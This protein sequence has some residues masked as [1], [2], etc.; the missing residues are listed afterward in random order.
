MTR[1]HDCGL[2]TRESV[3]IPLKGV[4]VTGAIIGRSARVKVK[5]H[6]SNSESKAVEA[7]YKYP[8]PEN[9][10]V[11]GF[12]ATVGDRVWE[13]QIEERDKAFSQYDEALARGDG[14]YLLDEERPNI[15]TLS[16]GNLNPNASAIVE[17][18]YVTVLDAHGQ[19]VRF[20]LPTTISPRYVRDDM[21]EDG[22]PVADRVNPVYAA[23]VPY[24][25]SISLDI[26]GSSGISS[27]D[28]PSHSIRTVFCDGV[29][30]V[31][32]SA[33]TVAMDRDFLLDVT[34]KDEF[35]NRSF[36]YKDQKATYIQLD[37]C[38]GLP[39]VADKRDRSTEIVFV[40]DCSGSMSGSSIVEA[41][42]ALTVLLK[43]MDGS[44]H[45]NIYRFGSRFEKLFQVSKPYAED[46]LNVA[47][48]YLAQVDA[49]LGGTELLAP[50]RD[51]YDRD[52][53]KHRSRRIVLITDGEIGNEQ[54]VSRLV[55]DNA[56]TTSLFVV[57]IGHGPN[58]YLVKQLARS[59]G[60]AAECIAPGDRIEPR[61]LRLF[62]KVA[63]G[64]IN[65]FQIKW[66]CRVDQAPLNP[67]VYNG[68]AISLYG[69]ADSEP[70]TSKQIVISG[71]YMGTQRE[72]TV[73]VQPVE[74]VG[75][76][77]SLLWARE[78]IRDLEEGTAGMSG[79]KQLHRK[80]AE[81]RNTI[82]A[83][84]KEYGILSRETSFVA[85]EKRPES[86]RTIGEVVLRKIPVMLTKDWHG[87]VRDLSCRPHLVQHSL[88][89]D[90]AVE[91]RRLEYS[92]GGPHSLYREAPPVV[93]SVTRRRT[94]RDD[95]HGR[96]IAILASQSVEGG[97]ELDESRTRIIG[98]SYTDLRDCAKRIVAQGQIDS[99]ILLSTIIVLR[100]LEKEF[101]SMIAIWYDV[102][103][104]SRDWYQHQVFMCK[105]LLD[106]RDLQEWVDD[107]IARNK[108]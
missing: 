69:K 96:L 108:A 38:P 44:M 88:Y 27:I 58:E 53:E 55:Q 21:E 52:T 87:V 57:G 18:D 84:S 2:L 85:L 68:E 7:I 43:G 82:I 4:Q 5:Q 17:I 31:E 14:A 41:K 75:I 93:P 19:E 32:F 72:W 99:W 49:D 35:R 1:E 23:S 70:G 9:S 60:G 56:E 16:L 77:V 106:G 94:A 39:V 80:D 79:S 24:G 15:F 95:R 12:K 86:Q 102:T 45:F 22:L 71:E 13:G 81:I 64:K 30:K 36:A 101:S 63:S 40:L 83:L 33:E 25:L 61:V 28:S 97:F 91:L 78:R 47:I 11:C 105:P 62:K 42:Q 48:R 20:F 103:Q 74:G 73:E 54:E 92:A 37:F 46:H 100:I 65:N 98:L 10:A 6:F 66:G 104:K 26:H 76:P 50:L 90:S 107:Y 8:L 29:V 67:V 51:I 89:R 59:S 34:Y 3:A